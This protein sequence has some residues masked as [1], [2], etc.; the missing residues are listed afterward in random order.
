[1]SNPAR[2][3]LGDSVSYE[4]RLYRIVSAS[5][6]CGTWRYDLDDGAGH[7]VKSVYWHMLAPVERTP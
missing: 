7:S 2:F 6:T 3:G 1:M 5:I 4:G